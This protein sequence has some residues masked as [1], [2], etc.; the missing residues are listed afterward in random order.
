MNDKNVEVLLVCGN[1]EV[2][3]DDWFKVKD[4]FKSIFE[5]KD[6]NDNYVMLVFGNWNYYV[7]IRGEKKVFKLEVI[8][9]EKV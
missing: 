4:M 6:G 2:K 1:L 3:I 9:L 5:I 7:V 8:Y